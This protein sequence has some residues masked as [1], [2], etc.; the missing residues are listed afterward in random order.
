M[1]KFLRY[2]HETGRQADVVALEVV[3]D[4][5]ERWLRARV[6]NVIEMKC[7]ARRLVRAIEAARAGGRGR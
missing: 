7:Y 2:C 6:R 3:D 4:D 1:A 5:Y